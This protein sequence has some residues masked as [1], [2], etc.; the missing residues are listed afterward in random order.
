MLFTDIQ[1]AFFVGFGFAILIRWAIDFVLGKI[2]E[3]EDIYG[4]VI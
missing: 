4:N 3:E 2:F 1:M